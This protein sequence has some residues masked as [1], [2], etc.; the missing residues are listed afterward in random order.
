MG[1]RLVS[2]MLAIAACA[3]CTSDAIDNSQ[4]DDT[5][6][7]GDCQ[8]PAI[9]GEWDHRGSN[10]SSLGEPYHGGSDVVANPGV[11]LE[12]ETRFIYGLVAKD[13]EEETV[14]L[15][16]DL[17]DCTWRRF[18]DA[19][20]D[21]SGRASFLISLTADSPPGRYPY[22]VV[23]KGDG[24]RA[25][26]TIW[27]LPPVD[28]S[29]VVFD[30][31]GTLTTGDIEII[32]EVLG[33]DAPDMREGAPEVAQA[34]AAAGHQPIYVT[35]RP[36]YGRETTLRWLRERGFPLGPLFLT[37][38]ITQAAFDARQYKTDVLDSIHQ[39]AAV[40]YTAAYG[41]SPKDIC[42]YGDTGID[43]AATYIAGD[44]GGESCEDHLPTQAVE[45]YRSHLAEL[46][47]PS[48]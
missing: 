41:N 15:W 36:M 40:H 33:G 10:I 39:T 14:S 37:T 22:E 19:V 26:G 45:G 13:L 31:D 3:A 27:L 9:V 23:V 8:A 4:F 38:S 28:T 46:E 24:S 18:G 5:R 32:E 1:L 20:T 30:V 2:S 42:A 34:W 17:G 12:L 6:S 35:G 11:T 25:R 29:L 47:I 7:D 43:P 16:I 48:P 21:D 44:H